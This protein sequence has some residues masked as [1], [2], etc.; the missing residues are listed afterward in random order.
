MVVDGD[1]V[2]AHGGKDGTMVAI[3]NKARSL[4][5]R[6]E[7]HGYCAHTGMMRWRM[8]YM[9][10]ELWLDARLVAIGMPSPFSSLGF[11]FDKAN[12]TEVEVDNDGVLIL[13]TEFA[14]R[15]IVDSAIEIFCLQVA[16]LGEAEGGE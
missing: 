3:S 4:R 12:V 15:E 7:L 6:V 1:A 11:D 8:A 13:A 10:G 5:D 2:T 14:S 16:A 9:R